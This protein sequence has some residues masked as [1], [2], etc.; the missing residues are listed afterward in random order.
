MFEIVSHTPMHA[1]THARTHP[2]THKR[3]HMHT[4][5][6][7]HAHARTHIVLMH[8]HTC[9]VH[10]ININNTYYL[11]TANIDWSWQ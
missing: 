2:H 1:R 11:P 9:T 5:A 10:K 6:H 8:I 7:T 4:H 3:T